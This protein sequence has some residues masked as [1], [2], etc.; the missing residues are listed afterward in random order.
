MFDS[1]DD[2]ITRKLVLRAQKRELWPRIVKIADAYGVRDERMIGPHKIV[3]R[4]LELVMRGMNLKIHKSNYIS[5]GFTIYVMMDGVVVF[6]AG[7]LSDPMESERI[8]IIGIDPEFSQSKDKHIVLIR[9]YVPGS[10]E[11]LF[12]ATRFRATVTKVAVEEARH[13]AD[14]H[15]Q[16]QDVDLGRIS[17]G[18]I[19]RIME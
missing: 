1:D 2:S 5:G 11:K 18:R 17:D 13:L 10:W 14:G 6:D 19:L 3:S 7:E 9:K 8:L 15:H 12:N 16:S 4:S